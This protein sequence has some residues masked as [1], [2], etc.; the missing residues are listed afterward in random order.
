[1]SLLVEICGRQIGDDE[2]EPAG[3]YDDARQVWSSSVA[4]PTVEALLVTMGKG[5]STK[6]I[7]TGPIKDADTDDY[8]N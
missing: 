4:A 3:K 8:N 1:M 7:S 2:P 5:K 6:C